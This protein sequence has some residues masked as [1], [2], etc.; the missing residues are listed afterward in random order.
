MDPIFQTLQSQQ[1]LMEDY[2]K[3]LVE[4]E[5]PSHDKEALDEVAEWLSQTFKNLTGGTTTLIPDDQYGNH[6]R[7]EFG[8]GDSQLLILSHFDT[9]WPKGTLERMPF[10]K[11]NGIAY[12]PG[13]FDMKSGLIQG[14]FAL[15]AL[16]DAG[17]ELDKK[18]VFFFDSDEE[19]GNP[20]SRTYI[21]EE[22]K[23]SDAV[24]VLEPALS[25]EGSL[26][27]SRKG[28]AI[29]DIEVN[30]IS[31]HAGIA[32]E[33]GSSAITELAYQTLFLNSLNDYEQ[34]TT[35]N[36]GK[37]SGGTANNVVAEK[38]QATL[39]V[40]AKTKSEF[41]R[42]IPIIQNLKPHFKGTEVIARGGVNRFPLERDD[43][44]LELFQTAQEIGKTRLNIE[45]TEK[46]TGGGSD[47]NLTAPLA[48]TLDGLGAVGRGAHA[49]D[50]QIVLEKMSER[51]AL[52]TH[53]LIHYGKGGGLND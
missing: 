49:I 9:V 22:A 38:S 52:L 14:L 29:Y 12:G 32:P 19:I 34:G 37:V 48:P 25:D 35:F 7:C 10:K 27:T 3:T 1:S 15:K 41:D 43:R 17:I 24:F 46:E 40:R 20:S 30:G 6:V 8:Q 23:K 42:V 4:M 11:E 26:K 44:V 31:A 13:V 18:V 53:L 16:K 50:E 45:L 5:S 28:V 39:D 21:E 33:E 2:L 36:V 51:A 47:G